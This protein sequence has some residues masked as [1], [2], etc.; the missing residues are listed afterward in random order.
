MKAKNLFM[1]DKILV[2][3]D[4]A[5]LKE[6]LIALL[7]MDGFHAYGASNGAEA[8][9]ILK[10]KRIALIL[11]DIAMPVM[12]GVELLKHVKDNTAYAHI[13]FL[14]LTARTSL[15][16]KLNALDLMADD[17]ITKPFSAKEVTLKC[18]NHIENRKRVI[19]SLVATSEETSYTSRD[20]KFVNDLNAFIEKNL[21]NKELMLQDLVQAFPMSTS[22]IQKN[23]K[24]IL[25]KSVFQVILDARLLKAKEILDSK[26]MNVT[27]VIQTCGFKNH[28]HFTRKFKEKFGVLPSKTDK[29]ND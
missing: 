28:N 23:V 4:D 18:R 3:E 9:K 22:S 13:P 6:N 12:D 11:S 5:I 19:K 2:V 14:M 20:Q 10:S 26:A 17:F 25:G 24:R 21:G 16:D 7:E 1:S 15:E 29:A 27:Q 8:L